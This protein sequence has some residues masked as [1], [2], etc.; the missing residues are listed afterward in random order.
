MEAQYL[1]DIILG[2]VVFLGGWILKVLTTNLNKLRDDQ[3]DMSNRCRDDYRQLSERLHEV[4]LDLPEKYVAKQDLNN[5]IEFINE[6]F[7]KLE[8][9]IDS[10]KPKR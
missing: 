9:K 6:R 8:T 2:S 1:I 4:A 7:N 5:L 10:L 3:N